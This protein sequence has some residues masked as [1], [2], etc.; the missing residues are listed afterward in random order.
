M[1]Q[2]VKYDR[3]Q[4]VFWESVL[5]LTLAKSSYFNKFVADD[6]AVLRTRM[7]KYLR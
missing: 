1:Y 5:Y 6:Y 4:V 2:F 7:L 3:R